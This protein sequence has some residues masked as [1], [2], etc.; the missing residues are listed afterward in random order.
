MASLATPI[1]RCCLTYLTAYK[2]PEIIEVVFVGGARGGEGGK[3]R[4]REGGGRERE[5]GGRGREGEV[6]EERREG[7]E[8][9]RKEGGEGV[10]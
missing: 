4:E 2:D 7:R 3:E 5:G 8:R 1:C 10:G 6:E 9:G